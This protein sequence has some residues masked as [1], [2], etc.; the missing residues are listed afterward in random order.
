METSYIE[1]MNKDYLSN[2]GF[3]QE[4]LHFISELVKKGIQEKLYTNTKD[5]KHDLK[6]IERVLTYV[7]WI[8]NEKKKNYFHKWRISIRERRSIKN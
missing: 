4:E 8:L 1:V 3:Q 7:Q 5:F 2:L 6:H